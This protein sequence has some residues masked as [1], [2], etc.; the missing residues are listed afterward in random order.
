MAPPTITP[1][2]RPSERQKEY[3]TTG[4]LRFMPGHL[5]WEL[6]CYSRAQHHGCPMLP[7]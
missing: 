1:M 4:Q 2:Q 7:V 5:V 6:T 3:L